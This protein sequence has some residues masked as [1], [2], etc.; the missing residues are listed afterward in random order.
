METKGR[1]KRRRR[2]K[3]NSGESWYGLREGAIGEVERTRGSR[4]FQDS[5][6]GTVRRSDPE[7][8]KMELKISNDF[9]KDSNIS[10]LGII[11]S[12]TSVFIASM[13]MI[14]CK[15]A[16]FCGFGA[17][18]IQFGAHCSTIAINNVKGEFG[19]VEERRMKNNRKQI[20]KLN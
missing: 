7:V 10:F 11:T 16:A 2:N 1:R 3:W 20:F 4:R 5:I 9:Q 19:R 13:N 15:C 17:I 12:H 8:R 14:V 18:S 6:H